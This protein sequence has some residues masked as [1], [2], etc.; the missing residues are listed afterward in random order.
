MIVNSV[1]ESSKI[2]LPTINIDFYR[3]QLEFYLK[4]YLDKSIAE[5]LQIASLRAKE[6]AEIVMRKILMPDDLEFQKDYEKIE[7]HIGKKTRKVLK[8]YN[9]AIMILLGQICECIIIDRCKIDPV[10]NMKCINYACFKDDIYEEYP[11]INY[12]IYTPLSPSHKKII[13]YSEDNIIYFKDNIYSYEPNHINKDIIWCNKFHIEETLKAKLGFYLGDAK[14][15]IKA[16]IDFRNVF[17][18]IKDN[19]YILSPIIYFDIN[20][21]AKQLIDYAKD[22]NINCYIKSI[23][24]FDANVMNECT[25]YYKILGAYF[26][27]LLDPKDVIDTDLKLGNTLKNSMIKY[28]FNADIEA[29]LSDN[30]NNESII[31][32]NNIIKSFEVGNSPQ[33]LITLS[34]K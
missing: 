15:Q 10:F 5:S 31:L 19:K 8:N 23:S 26:S 28:L 14:L 32:K 24:S 3:E 30:S 33:Q 16:S 17:R 9:K 21:D 13:V 29:L 20:N 11:D 2:V 34:S 6:K 27:G 4:Y 25:K 7:G 18:Q 12:K 22:N 1:N